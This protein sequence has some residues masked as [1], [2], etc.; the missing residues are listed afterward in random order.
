MTYTFDP[1]VA[2]WLTDVKS[3]AFV[4]GTDGDASLSLSS[5]SIE[6]VSVTEFDGLVKY[7]E[8]TVMT[9]FNGMFTLPGSSAELY[10]Q[11]AL[12]ILVP[13]SNA[14]DENEAKLAEAGITFERGDKYMPDGDDAFNATSATQNDGGSRV[15][16]KIFPS[17]AGERAQISVTISATV[18]V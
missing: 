10:A 6:E 9:E 2:T 7:G 1:Y 12:W 15:L 8:D 17:E 5:Y 18:T 13:V 11:S 4:T 16:Y 3:H 14:T